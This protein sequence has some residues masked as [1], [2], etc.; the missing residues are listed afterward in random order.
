M[1]NT[2]PLTGVKIV[3]LTRA[4]VGPCVGR[5]LGD[6]GA[7]IIHV[8]TVRRTE[9][10]RIV[11]P[12]KDGISGINRAA[13]FN[14]YNADKYGMTLDLTQ[15]RGIEVMHR[16]IQ[17]A[18][19]YTESNVPGV[20]AKYGLDYEGVKKIKPDIIMMSTC[21]MGQKGP[22]AQFKGL[23]TQ[24]AAMAGFHE[25]TGYQD[26]GPIG[27]FGS[28]TDMV[29]P[30]FLIAVIVAALIYRKRTGK[31]QYIDHSQLETGVHFLAPLILDHTANGRLPARI[32]NREEYAAPHGAYRCKGDD[33]WCTIAVYRD[34]EWEAFCRV[35]GNPP[36]TKESKFSSLLQRKRNEDELDKL[37]ESWTL[38]H[39][40]EE[41]MSLMQQAGVAAG[42]VAK[43]EDLHLDPQF[44]YQGHFKIINHTEIGEIPLDNPPF[45][46]SKTPCEVR[47][48]APCMGEHNEY[49]CQHIL[50]MSD[51]EYAELVQSGILQ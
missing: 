33:R 3:E 18:D 16:L 36:W 39:T 24:S 45:R 7:T 4:A 28:Y 23:G 13:Y 20:V 31:G 44:Q 48:S 38:E 27:P 41:V 32:G 43:A 26:S 19:I 25:L 11:P 17:W 8:E 30:Q 10:L 2:L 21:Q 12:F 9:L 47:M 5:I 15:P 49:I 46:F 51:E 40:S 34:E 6:C 1:S 35:I 42:M 22:H 29:S 37:V 14:K 50:G